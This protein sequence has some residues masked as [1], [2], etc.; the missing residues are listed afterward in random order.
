MPSKYELENHGSEL[1]GELGEKFAMANL[2]LDEIVTI[3]IS[4][5]ST[6]KSYSPQNDTTYKMA[7]VKTT[8]K[9]KGI[10]GKDVSKIQKDYKLDCISTL[11][12]EE[13][14]KNYTGMK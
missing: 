11:D 8:E 2:I 12:F 13:S 6:V 7:I 14:L 9:R 1:F 4:S 10:G 3:S 5:E